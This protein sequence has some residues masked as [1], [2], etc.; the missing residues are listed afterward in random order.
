MSDPLP[1]A[2]VLTS[3]VIGLALTAFMLAM[4]YRTWQLNG[5]DEVQDDRED[6]RIA[7]AANHDRINA[8]TTD[9]IGE[10]TAERADDFYDETSA[11]GNHEMPARVKAKEK[12][13]ERRENADPLEDPKGGAR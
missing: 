10:T 4:S 6:R 9:D 3:I 13:K 8:R 5:N 1:Q 11:A 12:K 2:M 7:L